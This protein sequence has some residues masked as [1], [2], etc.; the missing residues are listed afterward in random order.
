MKEMLLVTGIFDRLSGVDSSEESNEPEEYTIEDYQEILK[1]YKDAEAEIRINIATLYFEKEDIKESMKNLEKAI[2]IYNELEDMDK[3]ALVLDLMGDIN[4]FNKNNESALKN[5]R[6][7][8]QIYS[9][10]KS[11]KKEEIEEKIKGSRSK[12]NSKRC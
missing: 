9:E 3:K 10:I 11:D 7:A 12:N 4:R 2:D 8:Y 6:E 1:E 5:Y